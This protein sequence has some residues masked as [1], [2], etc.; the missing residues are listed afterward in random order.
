AP[1]R[2]RRRTTPTDTPLHD[3]PRH[4]SRS[5]RASSLDRGHRSSSAP[6]RADAWDNL[7]EPGVEG[8]G[9][10]R[11]PKG[12]VDSIG[13]G[14]DVLGDAL[15]GVV[16]YPGEAAR[17]YARGHVAPLLLHLDS[18]AIGRRA[19]DGQHELQVDGPPDG[20]RV[21]SLPVAPFVEDLV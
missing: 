12:D 18:E 6:R 4:W 3:Q 10:P 13:T 1:C 17:H 7:F 19:I 15:D 8:L 21:P 16:G 9:W 5:H 20:R 2:Y 14:V 11:R